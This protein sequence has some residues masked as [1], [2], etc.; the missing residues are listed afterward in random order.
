MVLWPGKSHPTYFSIKTIINERR[1]ITFIMLSKST[2]L[3][4]YKRRDIQEAIVQQAQQKEVSVR[5]DE[6]F[7]RRPDILLYPR[8]IL[9]LALQNATSF[10][11]SE[12]LWENALSLS[13]NLSRKELD[14]LRVGWDLV[15]DIDCAILDYSK[16]AADLIVKF[17][18]YCGVQDLSIKFSGNKGFHIGVPFEAFPKQIKGIP[19]KDLF[20]E[21]PRKIAFYIKENIATELAKRILQ[22]DNIATIKQKVG[23]E[24][25]REIIINNTLNVEKFLQ[26]D[27]IL[28]ASRHLYRMCYSLH[29]KSGLVSIPVDPEKI[30]DFQREMAIP[31]KVTVSPFVFL[32]RNVQGESARALLLQALDFKVEVK[33]EERER[34]EREQRERGRGLT[35]ALL[36]EQELQSPIKEEF[37]PPCMQ[38]ILG[39]LEDGRKR[40]VFCLMNY[41]GK[42]GWSKAEI[43]TFL[44]QWNQE[45][46]RV[47][48][49][50]VYIKGQLKH[51]KAGE[52]LPPNCNN[53]AYYENMGVACQGDWCAKLKNPVNYTL[54]RWR[55]HLREREEQQQAEERKGRRGRKKKS[56]EKEEKKGEGKKVE[57]AEKVKVD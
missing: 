12:E 14:S 30:M 7:G 29:E 52:R 36:E 5:Y 55:R 22:V 57:Q 47:P 48:L 9:E 40:G 2:L 8:E 41:L 51:F 34:R 19:T 6:Q 3:K 23:T 49:R 18:S 11:G 38:K 13:S 45:K 43:E 31:E 46:N 21:A 16:I 35:V 17:L 56:E 20:P 1:E 26:I 4:H 53:S 50:E 37:F 33:Q 39:G 25:L 24:E 54:S 10:H 42:I 32:N 44:V 28:L 15:L 27:T